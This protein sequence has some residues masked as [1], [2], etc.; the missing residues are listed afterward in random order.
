M[1]KEEVWSIVDGLLVCNYTTYHDRKMSMKFRLVRIEPKGEWHTERYFFVGEGN[2]GR[3]SYV[4]Y[5]NLCKCYTA[6]VHN[7]QFGCFINCDITKAKLQ[8]I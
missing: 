5:D 1:Q 7:T 3:I 6:L 8:P 2:K 4:S